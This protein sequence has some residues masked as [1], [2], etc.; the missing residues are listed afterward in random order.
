MSHGALRENL[1]ERSEPVAS[2]GPTSRA[3]IDVLLICAQ[4]DE[5]DEV[6]KVSD[7]ILGSG[8]FEHS[9]GPGGWVVAD[10]SFSTS[11]GRTLTVRATW[12]THM[13][14]ETTQATAAKL[15]LAQPA[16]CIAMSGICAGRRDDVQLGDVIFADL[17]WR[18]DAGK[19]MT[20]DGIEKF[21]A[22][23]LP[24]KPSPV[25]VQRM[26][27]V[28][29]PRQASWLIQRPMPALEAQEDWVLLRLVA[30]ENPE[31]DGDRNQACPDWQ[32]VLARLWKKKWLA[33][34]R[35]KLT[36]EGRK[37]AAM[38]R[39]LY[40]N[41][42]PPIRDCEVRVAPI[43]TGAAVIEDGG[44][45]PRLATYMRKVLGVEM[46]ASAV[47]ALGEVLGVPFVVAK[48]VSD[49]GDEFK[50][51]RYRSFAARAAAECLLSFLRQSVDLLPS[52]HIEESVQAH[53]AFAS[54]QSSAHYGSASPPRSSVGLFSRIARFEDEYLKSDR[55]PVP[56]GG[57]REELARLDRWLS[58]AQADPRLLITSPAGRGKSA[59]I[60]RWIKSLKEQS[61][62]GPNTWRL[63]FV[64]ISIRFETNAPEVF[65]ELLARE[66][67]EIAEFPFTAAT[68]D[69][70]GFYADQ[71]R[72]LMQRVA[73]SGR[74]TLV[75]L[76]GLDEALRDDSL[77]TLFP[78]ALPETLRIL[79]SARWQAGDTDASGWLARLDWPVP[80]SGRDHHLVLPT[81]DE[82][83]ISDLLIA[84]GSPVDVLGGDRSLICRLSKLS[85][86]EPLL[87]RFYAE[88]LWHKSSEGSAI[89]RDELDRMEPGFHA[90]FRRWI[91][92]QKGLVAKG[93][94]DGRTIQAALGI[95]GFAKGPLDGRDLIGLFVASFPGLPSPLTSQPLI[96]SLRRFVIGDGSRWAPYVL[97]HPRLA[98]YIQNEEAR[99][100]GDTI[101]QGF[102][103]WGREHVT[104]LNV[105]ALRLDE[106]S[107]YALQ[108]L[109]HHF[110]EAGAPAA[111]YMD[112]V[113][114]GWRRAWE[115]FEGG[116]RGFSADVAA[117]WAAVRQAGPL[118]AIGQQWRCALTLSSIKTL[119]YDM[120]CPL[121][122]AGLQRGVLSARQ[123]AHFAELMSFAERGAVTLARLAR[124]CGDNP[125]QCDELIS[126]ALQKAKSVATEA[127]QARALRSIV[128]VL[129]SANLLEDTEQEDEAIVQE[130]E[131][132]P[133][134]P[135]ESV[136]RVRDVAL[137]AARRFQDPIHRAALLTSVA[138][139][140]PAARRNEIV[141]EALGVALA[142][143]PGQDRALA[144]IDLV[145]L[146]GEPDRRLAVLAAQ[147]E[148]SAIADAATRVEAL[149]RVAVHLAP[150]E[151]AKTLAQALST[152]G[153][154]ANEWHRGRALAMLAP[155]VEPAQV[156]D[157]VTSLATLKNGYLRR[158]IV[159]RLAPKMSPEQAAR[160][161]AAATD[162]TLA[163]RARI[164]AALL[165]RLDAARRSEAI[166]EMLVLAAADEMRA[167]AYAALLPH[168]APEQRTRAIADALASAARIRSDYSRSGALIQLIPNLDGAQRFKA[169][170]DGIAAARLINGSSTRGSR[171]GS[172][173]PAMS[174]EQIETALAAAKIIE[175]HGPRAT[176]L[177]T[178]AVHLAP[179][180]RDTT[181]AEAL[182]VTLSIRDEWSRAY[183]LGKMAP[184]LTSQHVSTVIGSIKSFGR[185]SFGSVLDSLVPY[186]DPTQIAEVLAYD[187]ST[188]DVLAPY[189][190]PEHSAPAVAVLRSIKDAEGRLKIVEKLF[191]RLP[192]DQRTNVLGERVADILAIELDIEKD[193][194][195]CARTLAALAPHLP[196]PRRTSMIGALL[197][198]ARADDWTFVLVVDAL[199]RHLPS[200]HYSAARADAQVLAKS[201][202]S[203]AEAIENN[204]QRSVILGILSS[205][206]PP[207]ER[208]RALSKSLIA[209]GNVEKEWD[210]F[211]GLM[212]LAP[213][214]PSE[215]IGRALGIASNITDELGRQLVLEALAPYLPFE[216]LAAAVAA[217]V[218]LQGVS[219]RKKIFELL[220]APLDNLCRTKAITDALTSIGRISG[221]IYRVG[222]FN[223]LVPHL[224]TEDI[225]PA[226]DWI[227]SVTSEH[228]RVEAFEA[229]AARIGP[230]HIADALALAR[231]ISSVFHRA[232][233]LAAIA[234]L[235]EP[236]QLE[237]VVATTI[238]ITSATQRAAVLQQLVMHGSLRLRKTV[239]AEL[240]STAAVLPRTQE[241]VAAEVG[242]AISGLIGAL[243]A[244]EAGAATS[245]EIGGIEAITHMRRAVLDTAQWYP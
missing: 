245:F 227:K 175:D 29:M 146:L 110:D 133:E 6:C 167:E 178:L 199:A 220:F 194:M 46:E 67:A 23:I 76:D 2:L 66:L 31:S 182:G 190:K 122:V 96:A 143:T 78:R 37:R 174:A 231:S 184:Y 128:Q 35:I 75:V 10:G 164:A 47:G 202:L 87:L 232:R 129:A 100:L 54:E 243:R 115:R 71:A 140:T 32:K 209:T 137:A 126:A 88:D 136:D 134:L 8:W 56:F 211:R 50:D 238:V 172:L 44:I 144:V 84:M 186:L 86:G 191:S 18:Y 53:T 83:A 145:A 89:T 48:G 60:V 244:M 148:T 74:R 198:A 230:E 214:L 16:R 98:Q 241:L 69:P 58:D 176:T 38:L 121:I 171:L 116:Q 17:L 64:P 204:L 45:F 161:L 34:L 104:R 113:E 72:D 229:L 14:S 109:R 228:Y 132:I 207:P 85:E 124:L 101:R 94:P 42:F 15:I 234:Q 240:L 193:P 180:Q 150:G 149:V 200:K 27:Q 189:L 196:E 188:L 95:L 118:A 3:P 119:G 203:K 222:S 235:L 25:W 52:E 127:E 219:A 73:H 154:I 36:P 160:M 125:V 108:F 33:Q 169:I 205:Y 41:G 226:L 93:D 43:A 208:A 165:L 81:L 233:A 242:W 49:Y 117:A 221:D 159:E 13:G 217:T 62:I 158:P 5:Y 51:D 19:K 107:T 156:E 24:Y 55:S 112:L 97:N 166:D 183:V 155:H 142:L 80:R 106:A 197:T 157:V 20:E 99:D 153:E 7:G 68:T 103:A 162:G 92:Y 237:E 26:Q 173:A 201:L 63:A 236:A 77:S 28:K 91:G 152:A 70:A 40:P 163:D 192:P 210:R 216:H 141:S 239:L 111:A 11:D 30:G 187:A 213:H 57:R 59:L 225:A 185:M 39:V 147:E 65:Y 4:K 79:A 181:L 114:D 82:A 224:G 223:D 90:Y 130:P 179:D 168:L 138:Q 1:V 135:P 120:P 22:Q 218:T 151:R 206:L 12:A 215:H 123:A 61:L 9:G 177:A 195:A 139:V 212:Q 131:P 170:D 102:V 105:G 21:R